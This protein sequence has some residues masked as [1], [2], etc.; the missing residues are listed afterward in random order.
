MKRIGK[1]ILPLLCALLLLAS[2][3]GKTLRYENG[4]YTDPKTG[5]V[6]EHAPAYYEAIAYL[7]DQ[8]IGELYKDSGMT[9]YAIRDV[10]PERM[11]CTQYYEVLCAKGMKLPKLD[12]LK[13]TAAHITKTVSV[14]ATYATVTAADDLAYLSGVFSGKHFSASEIDGKLQRE[15]YELKLESSNLK[16]I[17]YCLTYLRFEEDV[18]IYED[19]DSPEDF[20]PTYS[21]DY[22]LHTYDNGSYYVAYNFGREILTN[23]YT[24]EAYAVDQMLANHLSGK[25]VS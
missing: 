17:R 24:D 4:Y 7:E 25:T 1:L 23:R 21:V 11:I 12:E 16:G 22:T 8:M 5:A 9:A 6:Y 14:S 18:M 10:D 20:T 15:K 2:C 13:L 19:I 3:G